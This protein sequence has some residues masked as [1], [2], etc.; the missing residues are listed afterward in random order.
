MTGLRIGI[1]G[2]T[3]QLARAL[4]YACHE[5]AFTALPL[6][7]DALDLS[8]DSQALMTS[9]SAFDGKVDVIINAAAYTDVDGAEDAETLAFQVNAVAPGVIAAYCARQDIPFVHVSTDYVFSGD[10]ER[11]YRETDTPR[12]LNAYGRSKRAGEEAVLA[13]GGMQAVLRTSWVYDAS[14]KNFVTSML[15]AAEDRRDVRVV[16]DQ[17]GRPT[18][19]PHL[20]QAC[21]RAAS[22]LCNASEGSEG[23]FHVT[24]TGPVISWAEFA[25]VIFTAAKDALPHEMN[26]VAIPASEYPTRAV[27]PQYSA[28][29]VSKFEQT[30]SY[31]LPHWLEGL[32][33]AIGDVQ[34]LGTG[35]H[36]KP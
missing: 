4:K 36:G 14:G 3:G 7:R 15:K 32:E 10:A 25:R 24:N 22:G 26:V 27:R 6:G 12:P 8:A 16:E 13:A 21:L 9:L 35:T 30:F 28:L 20:A 31:T 17:F 33:H 19:A 1:A 29:D 34:T 18:Y 23:L 11:P 2:K 5:N